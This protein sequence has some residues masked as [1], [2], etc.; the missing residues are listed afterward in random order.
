[1][2]QGGGSM[3]NQKN[4]TLELLKLFASY[5]V[6][7][8]HVPFNGKIGDVAVA[9]ARFAVPLFFFISG[10]YSFQIKPAKIIKRMKNILGLFMVQ[11]CATPC[12]MLRFRC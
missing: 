3:S 5:M 4:Y 6:V 9:L 1:M 12:F 11:L 7:F 2:L 10:Y 8:I